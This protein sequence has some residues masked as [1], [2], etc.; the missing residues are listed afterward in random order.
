VITIIYLH[1]IV[2][3]ILYFYNIYYIIQLRDK[4]YI[5]TFN[6]LIRVLRFIV[7]LILYFCNGYHELQL[8]S[9]NG[10]P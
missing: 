2:S 4:H 8:T 7:S 9:N 6:L 5:F 10:K 1:F 3:L